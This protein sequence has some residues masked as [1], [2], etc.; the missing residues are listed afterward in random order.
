MWKES[1]RYHFPAW[2]V[3]NGQKVSLSEVRGKWKISLSSVARS[4]RAKRRH[5]RD[6]RGT[7]RV[8]CHV[9]SCLACLT[10]RTAIQ[11]PRRSFGDSAA[12]GAPLAGAVLNLFAHVSPRAD[13]NIGSN[14]LVVCGPS[15]VAYRAPTS[16]SIRIADNV[17]RGTRPEP[18]RPWACDSSL[19][20]LKLRHPN[21]GARLRLASNHPR[22]C[23]PTH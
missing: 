23:Y 4:K 16:A 14:A 12:V 11:L 13:H 8:A 3:P 2:R 1:V 9:P 22:R 18:R 21:A 15:A 7:R 17:T 6:M 19:T 5:E 10:F 20:S